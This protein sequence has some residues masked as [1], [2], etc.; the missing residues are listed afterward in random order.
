MFVD[1]VFRDIPCVQSYEFDVPFML[2]SLSAFL[3]IYELIMRI[4]SEKI[5]KISVKEIMLE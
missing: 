2:I 1:I 3:V 5:R 4:Y